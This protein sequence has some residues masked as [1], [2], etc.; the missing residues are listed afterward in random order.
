MADFAPSTPEK[1]EIELSLPDAGVVIKNF[2]EYEFNSHFLTPTDAFTFTIGA[3]KLT[4][5]MKAA[6]VVGAKVQLKI[7]ETIQSTGYIDS[8]EINS[9][10]SSGTQYHICG[11][12]VLSPAIDS[13]ADPTIRFKDGQTLADILKALFK[14]FGWPDDDSFDIAND[15]SR[16][17]KTGGTRR[18]SKKGKPLKSYV[19]KP[20]RPHGREGLFEFATRISQRFSL[21]IW[22]S[23]DGKTLI[24]GRPDFEQE[25]IYKLFRNDDTLNTNVLD[26]SVKFDITDQPTVIVA[27]GAGGGGE[28]GRSR[29][30]SITANTCVCTT[31]TTFLEPWK[32]Y[33]DANRV[34]GHAFETPVAVPRNRVLY[35]HDD[36]AQT[37]EQLDNYVKREL[38]L[39]QRKS[40]QVHY[41]VEGHGQMTPDGLKIWAPDTTVRVED[42][43][44]RLHETLWVLSRTFIK[45]RHGGT[46]TRLELIRLNTISFGDPLKPAPKGDNG[47]PKLQADISQGREPPFHEEQSAK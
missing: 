10:R 5:E 30:R 9:D 15:A 43:I 3:A 25:P 2:T 41:T 19:V 35:L 44:G 34:D 31:D 38:A 39:L 8:I 24:I 32:K 14:P 42:D 28:W 45:S 20:L 26:G 29:L 36:E 6:L 37:Q 23:A 17:V 1:E 22:P 47:A 18:V 27:E 16:N 40:L 13:Q 12:D 21:W 33:K 7:N 4:D 11:R 46:K